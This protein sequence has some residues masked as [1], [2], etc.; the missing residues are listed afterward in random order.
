MLCQILFVS[1]LN[2]ILMYGDAPRIIKKQQ[3]HMFRSN[4][5]EHCFVQLGLTIQ[6]RVFYIFI[7]TFLL[8]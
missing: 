2:V 4:K 5:I 8:S 7:L 6:Q 3:I 1:R